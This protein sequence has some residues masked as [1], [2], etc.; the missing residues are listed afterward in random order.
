[1][2]AGFTVSDSCSGNGGDMTPDLACTS[3]GSDFVEEQ[4]AVGGVDGEA[5][6]ASLRNMFSVILTGPGG[7]SSSDDNEEGN[8]ENDDGTP[9]LSSIFSQLVRSLL[10]DLV[11]SNEQL[12]MQ[13]GGVPGGRSGKATNPEVVEQLPIIAANKAEQASLCPVCQDELNPEVGSGGGRAGPSDPE[14]A[15]ANCADG[16]ASGS[17][18]TA[19]QARKRSK[20][21]NL[22][23]K[24]RTAR[25]RSKAG[26][27]KK[28]TKAEVVARREARTANPF[29]PDA[30]AA[31]DVFVLPCSHQFHA[32]CLIPWLETNSSCPLCRA[33]LNTR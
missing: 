27:A 4:A 15:K 20:L 16:D 33:D 2:L 29:D 32:Q 23:T 28:A 7:W 9:D 11:S 8:N 12:A 31:T 3:C 5:M 25:A 1:M 10:A 30:Y 14:L 24:W 17:Q 19:P 22:L 21:R 13:S 6:P 18:A 26:R